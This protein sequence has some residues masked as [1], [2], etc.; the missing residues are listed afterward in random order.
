MVDQEL[1]EASS[2]VH[3]RQQVTLGVRPICTV[4][5]FTPST[6]YAYERRAPSN[7]TL[8][9]ENLKVLITETFEANHSVY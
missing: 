4:L 6:Y 1:D 5:K 3:R 7:R 8:R 9:D 2:G